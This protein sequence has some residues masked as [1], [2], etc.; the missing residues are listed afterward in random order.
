VGRKTALNYSLLTVP[1]TPA[2]VLARSVLLESEKEENRGW[3]ELLEGAPGLLA[4]L[5]KRLCYIIEYAEHA[6]FANLWMVLELDFFRHDSHDSNYNYNH[7][8]F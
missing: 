1:K 4:D 3:L 5:R 2:F 8:S 6:L 7:F